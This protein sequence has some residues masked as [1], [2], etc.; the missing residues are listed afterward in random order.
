MKSKIFVGLLLLSIAFSAGYC[1]KIYVEN[2]KVTNCEVTLL[3]YEGVI[4]QQ[5]KNFYGTD[6]LLDEQ[7]AM[8]YYA[9]MYQCLTYKGE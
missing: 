4:I 6:K 9:K 3:T 5:M 8:F 7:I 1:S 2:R